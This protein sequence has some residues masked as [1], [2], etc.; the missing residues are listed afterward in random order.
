MRYWRSLAPER[1]FGLTLLVMLVGGVLAGEVLLRLVAAETVDARPV[2]RVLEA[3][4]ERDPE[5]NRPRLIAGAAIGDIAINRHG[6]RGPDT[7]PAAAE[8][9]QR[10]ALLGASWL[11]NP[12][13]GNDQTIAAHLAHALAETGGDTCRVEVINAALP[14]AGLDDMRQRFSRDL[15]AFAPDL[16]VA[17]PINLLLDLRDHVTE[18]TPAAPTPI[19]DWVV[20]TSLLARAANRFR[21]RMTRA[22]AVLSAEAPVA[23]DLEA[24]VATFAAR[25][26]ALREEVSATGAELVLLEA[27]GRLREDYATQDPEDL[28]RFVRGLTPGLNVGQTMAARAAFNSAL[29]AEG[30]VVGNVFSGIPAN[31]RHFVDGVHM[32]RHGTALAGAA[33][34]KIVA[35]HVPGCS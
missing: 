29:A 32:T 26:A 13:V 23:V 14:S 27:G 16:V 10:I 30:S 28:A 2:G 21:T 35:P 24:A 25:L 5:T 18:P 12:H 9:T 34:A 7:Q 8:G 20:E 31:A 17:A 22:R 6:F 19:F 11:F 15:A 1:R 4:M 3:V 33:L